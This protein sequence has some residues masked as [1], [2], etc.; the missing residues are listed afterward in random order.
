MANKLSQ[1]E[2]QKRIQESFLQD[3]VLISEYAGKR[4][5]ITLRCN[6][7]SNEW[8]TRAQNAMFVGKGLTQH[9]CPNCKNN[10]ERNGQ[11]FEC[12]YCGKQ[13]Y[14]SKKDIEENKSGFYYCCREHG[15]IHKNLLRQQNGEWEDS[16]NYRLKAFAAYEHK[17]ACCGW[18]ED[19]RIL[20]V[21]HIDSNRQH[22]NIENL[23]ILCPNCHRKIT[24]GYYTFKDNRLYRS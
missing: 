8:S 9:Q 23:I 19:E 5:D 2:A 7:C 12:A 11:F 10:N 24:L 17:C 13:I 14:R 1:E 20:E 6:D 21:H 15:N 4:N 18:Q 16:T 22:N 3:V